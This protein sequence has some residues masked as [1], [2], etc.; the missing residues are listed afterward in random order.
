MVSCEAA[1]QNDPVEVCR[2]RFS[3]ADPRVKKAWA[4]I[5]SRSQFLCS[6]RRASFEEDDRSPL[7][8][9][10]VRS[11]EDCY[12][13]EDR[14]EKTK[15]EDFIAKRI[16]ELPANSP[17]VRLVDHL[18]PLIAEVLADKTKMLRSFTPEEEAE[19]QSL[20]KRYNHCGGPAGHCEEYLNSPEAL[21]MWEWREE[22]A[23]MKVY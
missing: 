15:Y 12:G 19:Y 22:T 3:S 21:D 2:I 10:L 16:K 4:L 17:V 5:L 18:P 23:D 14:V 20:Q 7:W 11:H 8:E 9:R 6:G 1:E 13:S